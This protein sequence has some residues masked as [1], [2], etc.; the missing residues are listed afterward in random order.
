M[1]SFKFHLYLQRYANAVER[2]IDLSNCEEVV[3]GS[4]LEKMG[5]PLEEVGIIIVNGKW[6]D[7][8]YVLKDGDH[9]E[10]FPVYLGG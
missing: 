6:Q 9:V 10:V 1:V 3:L 7:V 5:I 4:C 8:D 2:K